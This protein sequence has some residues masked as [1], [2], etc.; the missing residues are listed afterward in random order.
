MS[1]KPFCINNIEFLFVS[2]KSVFRHS[3]ASNV[4]FRFSTRVRYSNFSKSIILYNLHFVILKCQIF[5]SLKINHCVG[6][7]HYSGTINIHGAKCGNGTKLLGGICKRNNTM[8]VSDAYIEAEGLKD[9]K[10]NC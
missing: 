10:K 1:Y 6:G 9:L 4:G 3:L 2:S 7:R 8:V 5:K